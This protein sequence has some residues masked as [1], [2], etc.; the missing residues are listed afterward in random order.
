MQKVVNVRKEEEVPQF[1][2]ILIQ[3]TSFCNRKCEFCGFGYYEKPK[4]FMTDEVFSQIIK[5]LKEL[6]YKGRIELNS[7]NEPLLDKNLIE[8]I[9]Y[10]RKKL[11]NVCIMF[12][13]NGDLFKSD[14]D[15]RILFEAGLNQMEINVY[16]DRNRVIKIAE[17]LYEIKTYIGGLIL[18]GE[19]YTKVGKDKK[20]V[21]LID[22]TKYL[23]A[24]NCSVFST[25]KSQ[26]YNLLENNGGALNG[27]LAGMK[28]G[29]QN[30]I[31][32]FPFR[33]PI[34]DWKGNMLICCN[35]FFSK[36]KLGNVLKE[37]II[38]IWNSDLI[39]FYRLHLQNA[40]RS[41]LALC[42]ECNG[43]PGFYTHVVPKITFGSEK[44]DKKLLKLTSKE[45]KE[46]L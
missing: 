45:F 2:T 37:N 28:P 21:D 23:T 34:I 14:K 22:K 38:D 42:R 36:I 39:N 9:K 19:V 17:W 10:I 1:N 29:N 43:H 6:N 40:G 11:P 41:K 46:L 4:E 7:Y 24:G 31:C 27:K 13:T 32:V 12:N 15:I 16:S 5:Q 35:D 30:K 26:I 25:K 3:T 18:G 8:K 33:R 44:I 20:V